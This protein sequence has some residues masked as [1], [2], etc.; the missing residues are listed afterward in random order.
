[1]T[2][3]IFKK[4]KIFLL[5]KFPFGI[6]INNAYQGTASKFEASTLKSFSE[7]YNISVLAASNIINCA[8]KNLILYKKNKTSSIINISSM[9]GS[10]AP[11]PKN[12]K[13]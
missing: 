5:N 1:M 6:I 3:W 12:M 7:A 10:I 11:D 4:L 13:K 2:F 8:K 9:Y